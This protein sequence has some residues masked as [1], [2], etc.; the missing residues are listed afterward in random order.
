ML[1][2]ARRTP[3]LPMWS[4]GQ[5]P[6]ANDFY[7]NGGRVCVFE[8]SN[9]LKTGGNFETPWMADRGLAQTNPT[10]QHQVDQQP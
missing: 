10:E 4:I 5:C 8:Y 6:N 3:Y 7:K 1:F 9:V 2:V